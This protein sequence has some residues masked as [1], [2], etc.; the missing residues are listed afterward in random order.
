MSFRLMYAVI[1]TL[2]VALPAAADDHILQPIDVFNLES[3]TDPQISP[4]GS[5]IVY[6]RRSNDI[7][8]D[9][10]RSSLWIINLDGTDHRPLVTGEADYFN[11]RWSPS[12]DRLI[13]VSSSVVTFSITS[14]DQSTT[15]STKGGGAQPYVRWMDTGQTTK[16][17]Q[18]RS[19]PGNLAWSPDGEQIAFTMFVA[20]KGP[21]AAALPAKPQGAEWAEPPRVIEA[22]TYKRDGQ[23]FTRPGATHVFVIP[24]GGGAARQ[25]T[26]GDHNHGGGLTWAPDGRSLLF[27]SN[28]RG[29]SDFFPRDSEVY[30]LTLATGDMR[31]ITDRDGP[32]GAPAIS[33]NGRLIAYTGY[34][35]RWRG[36]QVTQLYV[37]NRDGSGIRSLTP[38][39]DRSVRSVRWAADGRGLYFNYTSEGVSKLAYISLGGKMQ[40]FAENLGGVVF[41][42]PGS[43]FAPYS[44]SNNG[45]VVSVATTPYRPADL[46]V[47]SR[48][49][50][51]RRITDLNGDLLDHKTLGDVEELWWESSADGRRVQGWLMRPPNFDPSNNYPLILEIHGGPHS[52]YGPVFTAELQLMASAGYM[53]LYTNPRGS[54]SYGEEFS[55]LIHHNYPGEDY[56]DLISG[57]DAA[58]ALGN[59]DTDNL[60]VTGGSGGGVLSAWVVG[61]TDRFAGA[62][63][64]KPVINWISWTLQADLPITGSKYWFPAAPWEDPEGYWARSPLSLVGNVT[65]PTMLLTGEE[66]H[67]TPMPESEQYYMALKLRGVPTRLARIPGAD[68]GISNSRPSRLIAKVA[69]IVRWFDEHKRGDGADDE[70]H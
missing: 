39:L 53:V 15:V 34:D 36:F 6:V 50:D 32:D 30:E 20:G 35:E 37:M 25:L 56:D 63:V 14:G 31:E 52:S 38:D 49:G 57:V 60:F 13:Y 24:S 55:D 29:D 27:S 19:G 18:L 58:I 48:H 23:G 42:R 46:V 67:R 12:G 4:D 28:L 41:G 17:A 61:K 2:L 11:P 21:S 26:S 1:T 64:A 59:V 9:Q 33:P 66:D 8:T 43:G 7:M 47:G 65:T 54:T 45:H 10:T 44:V 5:R 22:F 16:L 69:E 68:H 51:M 62:V 40:T 70:A 3:A